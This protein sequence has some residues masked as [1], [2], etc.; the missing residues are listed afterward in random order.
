MRS[1]EGRARLRRPPA[2]APDAQLGAAGHAQ[3]R[4]RRASPARRPLRR[5]RSSHLRRVGVQIPGGGDARVHARA[6]PTRRGCRRPIREAPAHQPHRRR[7]TQRRRRRQLRGPR[8]RAEDRAA[9]TGSGLVPHPRAG[10]QGQGAAR[11]AGVRRRP[12]RV[13]VLRHPQRRLRDHR[14][15][16]RG[17]RVGHH[18]RQGRGGRHHEESRRVFAQGVPR[19]RRSL[20]ALV[21]A[22]TRAQRRREAGAGRDARR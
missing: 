15:D 21:R 18:A 6:S 4:N 8:E 17:R 9:G 7:A 10:G 20:R 13:H 12:R 5:V 1:H 3:A 16:P 11:A 2:Q 19:Q 14:R 22:A